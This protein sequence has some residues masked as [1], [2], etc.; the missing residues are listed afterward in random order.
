MPQTE[1]QHRASLRNHALFVLDGIRG[2]FKSL[3]GHVTEL[4][5][6]MLEAA[7]AACRQDVEFNLGVLDDQTEED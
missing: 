1:A 5:L 4:N 2:N 7:I 6:R 3:S